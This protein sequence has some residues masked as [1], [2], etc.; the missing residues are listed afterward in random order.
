[1]S[2]DDVDNP[3]ESVFGLGEDGEVMVVREVS[4]LDVKL[5]DPV[6]VA[7]VSLPNLLNVGVL[8]FVM[9][10]V[11]MPLDLLNVEAPVAVDFGSDLDHFKAHL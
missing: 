5:V 4:A 6:V 10:V 3:V 2:L 8:Q 7:D 9:P 1:M 11:V